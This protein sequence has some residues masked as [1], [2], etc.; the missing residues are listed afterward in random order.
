M[1]CGVV[2]LRRSRAT[3]SCGRRLLNEAARSGQARPHRRSQSNPPPASPDESIPGTR[4]VSA[5]LVTRSGRSVNATTHQ[6]DAVSS[7]PMVA[8]SEQPRRP[9]RM[10]KDAR[11][12]CRPSYPTVRHGPGTG[13]ERGHIG[14]LRM[15]VKMPVIELLRK[16]QQ[17]IIELSRDTATVQKVFDHLA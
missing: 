2:E 11:S 15:S 4:V 7:Q 16:V 17:R 1:N 14:G 5:E 8:L 9:L 12:S 10:R 13:E 3:D 6:G